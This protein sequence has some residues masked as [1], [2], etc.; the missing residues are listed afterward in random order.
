LSGKVL[1]AET[2]EDLSAQLKNLP[3]T[4]SGR[5]VN[6]SLAVG[7]YPFS[8]RDRPSV[9]NPSPIAE[10][11][12]YSSERVCVTGCSGAF[13]AGEAASRSCRFFSF[14]SFFACLVRSRSVRWNR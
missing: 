9:Q 10:V 6:R 7:T 11:G 4:S 1:D 12:V 2:G 8:I 13:A 5:E 3:A 14:S